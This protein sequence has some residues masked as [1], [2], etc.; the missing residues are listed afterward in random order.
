MA[1]DQVKTELDNE[2]DELRHMAALLASPQTD[3]IFRLG[4]SDVFYVLQADY[5]TLDIVTGSRDVT[6]PGD[7]QKTYRQLPSVRGD[8]T[9][10]GYKVE[11]IVGVSALSW[12]LRH[13]S[14][15]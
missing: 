9:A 7:K 2:L 11:R 1:T 6:K 10:H 4:D 3:V 8:V 12:Y 13:G 5:A 14:D 15:G